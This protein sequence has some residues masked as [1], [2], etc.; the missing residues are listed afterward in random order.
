MGN[1]YEVPFTWYTRTMKGTSSF[2]TGTTEG[3]GGRPMLSRVSGGGLEVG[4][5]GS[6]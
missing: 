5:S 3:S 1:L 4:L 6:A 2:L